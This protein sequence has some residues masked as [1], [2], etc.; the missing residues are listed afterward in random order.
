MAKLTIKDI[1]KSAFDGVDKAISGVIH[2]V[3]L[4]YWTES[5]VWDDA[6]GDY[7]SGTKVDLAGRG[8][9]ITSSARVDKTFGDFVWTESDR[10]FMLSDFDS[11]QGDW[12]AP[13]V[14]GHMSIEGISYILVAV[15]DL[16]G[17]GDIFMVIGRKE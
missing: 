5:S 2:S 11:T 7:T 6:R 17:A 1:A 10:A 3:T 4:S 15:L 9:E 14:G 8:V 13:E 12:K 16:M